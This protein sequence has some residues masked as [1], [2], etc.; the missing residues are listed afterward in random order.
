MYL[1]GQI[2]IAYP[3]T[4]GTLPQKVPPNSSYHATKVCY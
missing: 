2:F 4:G 3:S 1:I